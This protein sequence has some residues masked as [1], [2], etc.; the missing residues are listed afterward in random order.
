[1]FNNLRIGSRLSLGFGLILALLCLMAGI[2]AWQIGRLAANSAYYAE[3]LVP[4]YEAQHRIALA[5]ADVR[6]YET[7]H[8]LVT[9]AADKEAVQAKMDPL[10]KTAMEG[11]D[12]YAKA[13]VSDDEDKRILDEVRKAVASYDVERVKVR[14]ASMAAAADPTKIEEAS[15]ALVG[16]SAKAYESVQAKLGAWW[17]YN[18]R[19]SD[20]QSKTSAATHRSA[21]IALAAC[22][23]AALALGIAAALLIT[24]S[25]TRPIQRAVE[26]A[27]TVAAGDLR[28]RIEVT[29][30]DET[31]EL[32]RALS[33]MNDNLA[34]IVGQVRAGSDSIAT[35][36]SQ[37]ATGNADL[38]QRTEEQ[39]SNLQQTAASMEQ[40]SGT[41]KQSA[42]TAG[43][44]NQLASS[45]SAAAVKGGEMVGHVVATMQ[46]IAAASK[47]I[48]DIIGV[49][50]GIA[51]QTNI[52]ALNAAVEAARAGE[53]GRGF[54]VVAS[55]VRSLAGRSA[56]AAK[57]IKSLITAS[58]EKVEI[59]ARQVHDAGESMTAIVSQVRH[60]SQLISDISGASTEQS[61]GIV[62]IGEAV[63]QL[64]QVTQQNAALVEESAAAADSLTQQ[65]AKLT[66]LVSVFKIPEGA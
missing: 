36:S 7:R 16:E 52:L 1:M 29:G 61:S 26:L 18:V 5:L 13:L 17:A 42:H 15:K 54:A 48:S 56:D 37:I 14:Q 21:N 22:V 28:S 34:R 41:V 2:A 44:A 57:E 49:I 4:S 64:D 30:R 58:V 53:Q 27:T 8:V 62:Q 20:E 35:G 46:D 9:A 33:K 12:A 66:H 47:K 23:A 55:E 3:N 24:R 45:A 60:V 25:I 10:Y 38:S 59:G 39:A 65:A 11:L 6:R 32:L 19:L 63:T 43:E 51:F 50:D 40:L 31:A